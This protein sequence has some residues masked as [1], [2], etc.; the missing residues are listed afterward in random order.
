MFPYDFLNLP[1][2][3]KY[4]HTKIETVSFF[5]T[6]LH[7]ASAVK[8]RKWLATQIVIVLITFQ[9]DDYPVETKEWNNLE[10][11]ADTKLDN[12]KYIYFGKNCESWSLTFSMGPF[13]NDVMPG[14]FWSVGPTEV[15]MIVGVLKCLLENFQ[16]SQVFFVLSVIESMGVGSTEPDQ[17]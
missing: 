9:V 2:Y 10:D 15:M 3:E 13:R 7:C 4:Y 5:I 14:G 1:M 8:F 12:P 16:L 6:M 11:S 17:L